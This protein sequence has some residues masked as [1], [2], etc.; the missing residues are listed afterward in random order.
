[1][2][3]LQEGSQYAPELKEIDIIE[4]VLPDDLVYKKLKNKTL[5]KRIEKEIR[6]VYDKENF[7]F[8]V[9]LTTGRE[10]IIIE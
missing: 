10:E 3:K 2:Y 4:F 1:M 8:K 5:L 9:L 7:Y 6:S